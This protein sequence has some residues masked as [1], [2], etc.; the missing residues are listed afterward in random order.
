M[1]KIKRF[2]MNLRVRGIYLFKNRIINKEG[3]EAYS[4]TLREFTKKKYKVEV[5]LYSYGC[6]FQPYFNLGGEVSIGNYCSFATD[7]HYFGANHPINFASM[8]PFFYNPVF[9]FDVQDVKREKLVIGHD[10]WCGYGVIITSKCHSIGNGAVIGA[11]S[12]VTKDIPPY[13]IVKGSPAVICKYRF[14]QETINIL[15][16]SRWFNLSPSELMQ[17]YDK[18]NEPK[19]FASAIIKYCHGEYNG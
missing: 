16:E 15:E 2:F 6:C 9:G 8:S 5:G 10:V 17:F 13:A 18:I 1:K 19:D 3:G 4:E 11:G 12:I 14:D 7:I